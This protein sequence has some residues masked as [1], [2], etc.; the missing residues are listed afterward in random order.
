MGDIMAITQEIS[1]IEFEQK[2]KLLFHHTRVMT[3]YHPLK[4]EFIT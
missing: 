2:K 4:G 1:I 3:I